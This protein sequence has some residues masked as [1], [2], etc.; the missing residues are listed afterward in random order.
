MPMQQTLDYIYAW[1]SA[2]LPPA[3]APVAG[4]TAAA[5]KKH[6]GTRD[7]EGEVDAG[8]AAAAA[9]APWTIPR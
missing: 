1:Q 2:L 6:V 8:A 9:A 3:P 5:Q 7:D 4:N